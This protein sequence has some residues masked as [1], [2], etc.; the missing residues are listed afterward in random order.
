MD[1][2]ENAAINILHKALTAVGL[3]VAACGR[4]RGCTPNDAGMPFRDEGKLP[5]YS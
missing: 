4:K 2:D 1:R 3:T 5:L